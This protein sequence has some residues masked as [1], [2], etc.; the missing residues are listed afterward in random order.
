M[1]QQLCTKT[2]CGGGRFPTAISHTT[3]LPACGQVP[4]MATDSPPFLENSLADRRASLTAFVLRSRCARATVLPR[5]PAQRSLVECRPLLAPDDIMLRRRDSAQ[6][7]SCQGDPATARSATLKNGTYVAKNA[8]RDIIPSLG[9]WHDNCYL[10]GVC[11]R[12]AEL[13]P[14]PPFR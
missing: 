13:F 14:K 11:L 1:P 4:Q 6:V 10:E 7:Q 2:F 9:G 12:P 3:P 8:F 5:R